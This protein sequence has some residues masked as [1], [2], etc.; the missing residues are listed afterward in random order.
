[1]FRPSGLLQGK[2]VVTLSWRRPIVGRI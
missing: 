1:V 2:I